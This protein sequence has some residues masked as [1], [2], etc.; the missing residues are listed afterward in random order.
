[1]ATAG[2]KLEIKCD[3][4]DS[5]GNLNYNYIDPDVATASVQALCNGILA[6]GS[7][8]SKTPR[9][10]ISANVVQTTVREIDL[11]S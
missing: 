5:K 4:M 8:F 6:N 3:Y 9:G 2:C 11:N 7:I 1:M 10:I